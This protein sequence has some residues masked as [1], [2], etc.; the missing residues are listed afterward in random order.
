MIAVHGIYLGHNQNS[1]FNS[2]SVGIVSR[3]QIN[4]G[5]DCYQI[6]SSSHV[7]FENNECVGINLFSRG[8]AAGS[9]Y[10]GPAYAHKLSVGACDVSAFF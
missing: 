6:D 3:N 1:L 10:G 4:F 5:G 7:I 8:S 2:A 9:T